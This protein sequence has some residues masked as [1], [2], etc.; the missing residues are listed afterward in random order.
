MHL[1]ARYTLVTASALAVGS[2]L[3]VLSFV[4][5]DFVWIHLV[6]LDPKQIGLGDG[7]M[8]VGGGF[9]LGCSLGLAGL[10]FVLLRFWPEKS[11]EA[12][13]TAGGGK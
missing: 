8:V 12:T 11:S 13:G 3:F 4:C 7:V 5:V 10:I 1:V 9:V 6:V 2:A